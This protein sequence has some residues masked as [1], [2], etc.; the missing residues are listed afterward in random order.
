MMNAVAWPS[1]KLRTNLNGYRVNNILAICIVLRRVATPI[2]WVDIEKFFRK[3][4]P[5]L[6]ECFWEEMEHM[7]DVNGYRLLTEVYSSFLM[8]RAPIYAA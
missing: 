1:L 6:S 7:M 8:H 3:R 4:A 5:A 2:C